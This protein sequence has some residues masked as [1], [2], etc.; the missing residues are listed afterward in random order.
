MWWRFPVHRRRLEM[1]FFYLRLMG[2]A[3]CSSISHLI[4]AAWLPA[5]V[6]EVWGVAGTTPQA[7]QHAGWE[8]RPLALR[9]GGGF[10]KA[11]PLEMNTWSRAAPRHGAQWI[12]RILKKTDPNVQW[13]VHKSH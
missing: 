7:W 2:Q 8:W 6:P 4:S 12:W 13:A 3:S 10:G 11:W 1:D 5:G 9:S